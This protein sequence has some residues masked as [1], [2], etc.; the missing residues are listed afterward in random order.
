MPRTRLPTEW[1][2]PLPQT[3][4]RAF[5]L[6]PVNLTAALE[7][8]HKNRPELR[9]LDLQKDINTVD[10]QY[11]KNQTL[12]QVDI[13]STVA[14]PGLPGKSL[15]LPAG[16]LVPLIS[17]SPTASSSAFLSSQITDINSKTTLS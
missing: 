3:D 14:S 1:S 10:L 9:R 11:Y 8:A 17:G 6:S 7:E 16:T 12:P 4:T 13:Q 15:G 2:A 5:D